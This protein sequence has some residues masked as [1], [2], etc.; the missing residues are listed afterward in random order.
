MKSKIRNNLYISSFDDID[1]ELI[2]RYGITA[3]LN[4]ADE[5][6]TPN[7]KGINNYKLGFQ[8]NAFKIN[9]KDIKAK[10]ILKSLLN[11]GEIV[12]IHCRVGASRSPHV[13]AL[14][15]SDLENRDYYDVYN[16]IK[17][18]HPRTISYSLGQEMKDKNIK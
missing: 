11:K 12:L 3:I 8:D 7:Y 1:Q 10:D 4:V 13:M 16:E 17:K 5:L 2:D 14:A 18:L 6:S 15:L 9:G